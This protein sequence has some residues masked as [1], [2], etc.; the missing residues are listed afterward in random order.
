MAELGLHIKQ[1][2]TMVMTP[3]LQQS[4]KMLQLTSL[5]LIPYIAQQIEENPFLDNTDSTRDEGDYTLSE[6]NTEPE[7]IKRTETIQELQTDPIPVWQDDEVSAAV[8]DTE[9]P[10]YSGV[11]KGAGSN[12][13]ES[14]YGIENISASA[15]T[16]NDHIIDQ[17]NIYITDPA[18]RLIALHLADMLDDSGYIISD[19]V[20]LSEVLKCDYQ[21]IESVLKVLQ[22]FDPAGVFAR[23][24]SECLALQLK[25]KNRLDPAMQTLLANLDLFAKRDFKALCK[26]CAVDEEDLLEMC[27]EVK[28]LNPKPGNIFSLENVQILYPDVFL[29]K[30][31]KG[32]WHLELNTE[33][34]PKVLVNRR[35]YSEVESQ[36][37]D[38]ESKRFLSEQYSNANWLV[39]ALDQRANTILKVATEIVAQQDSFFRYGIHHIKPLV[40]S[41]IAEGIDMHEST[42][43]RVINGKHIAT[44]MGVYEL[45]YFFSSAVTSSSSGEDVSSKRIKFMIK[46]LIDNEDTKKILSDDKIAEMLKESGVEVARRTVMKYREAMN[47]PSSVQRRREKA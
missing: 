10:I 2:Q 16:L 36:V 9:S 40:L 20:P 1:S 19:L 17:I 15:E 13:S 11:G 37:K 42:V 29:K 26:I 32:K 41:D 44:H 3:Q 34:L 7:E 28:A 23:D 46:S 6:E 8:Y 33:A 21:K 22:G 24:L 18:E 30:G 47:I 27:E 38:K 31:E 4:I 35:Y 43:S 14:D 39:K 25:E 45:K 5:D 12:F